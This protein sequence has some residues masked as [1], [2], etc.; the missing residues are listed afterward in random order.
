MRLGGVV[1]F[2]GWSYVALWREEEGE[3]GE[4]GVL[5]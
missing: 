5:C 3:D 4:D 1:W 2:L